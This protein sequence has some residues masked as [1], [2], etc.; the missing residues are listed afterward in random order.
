MPYM[1]HSW[2][3]VGVGIPT[4]WDGGQ[5]L[6][7]S[8]A[9]EE[10]SMPI[11][12]CGAGGGIPYGALPGSEWCR[13]GEPRAT[14]DHPPKGGLYLLGIFPSGADVSHIPSGGGPGGINKPY[15]T[16]G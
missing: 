2:W 13:T 8:A 12:Q 11:V 7:T 14:L 9:V 1:L 10:D 3:I 4:T 16:P 6:V 15:Q 5:T